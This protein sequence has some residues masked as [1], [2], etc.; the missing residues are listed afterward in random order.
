MDINKFETDSK[1]ELK[2]KI[3]DDQQL[4]EWF[5]D[6]CI[7][8]EPSTKVPEETLSLMERHEIIVRTESGFEL[9]EIGKDFGRKLGLIHGEGPASLLKQVL[10]HLGG[11]AAENKMEG[12]ESEKDQGEQG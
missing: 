6:L 9:G 2:A 5:F 8:R 1:T 10:E 4:S 12:A 11:K 7:G 3:L